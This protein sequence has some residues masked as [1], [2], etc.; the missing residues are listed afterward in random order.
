MVGVLSSQPSRLPNELGPK[1]TSIA[2]DVKIN[3]RIIVFFPLLLYHE[4][5]SCPAEESHDTHLYGNALSFLPVLSHVPCRLRYLL[6]SQLLTLKAG[7]T[8]G[9]SL[10]MQEGPANKKVSISVWQT[11]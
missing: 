5:M 4:L 9:F 7:P 8:D 10:H 11:L 6:P 3:P 1:R 2:V